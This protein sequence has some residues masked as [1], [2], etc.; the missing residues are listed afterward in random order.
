MSGLYVLLLAALWLGLGW[1]LLRLWRRLHKEK[2]GTPARA[3]AAVLLLVVWVGVPWYYTVGRKV[4][5]DA[6]VRELCAKDGGIKV[7]EAVKLP[8]EK[9]D[10]WGMVKPYDPTQGENALG[11]EYFFGRDTHYFRRGNPEIW[12]T[13]IQIV[14]RVDNKMLGEATRYSRRGGDLPGPW[15]ES[16]FAC[17][18]EAGQEALIQSIFKSTNEGGRQ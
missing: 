13:H 11:S 5:L 3:G 10:K 15:H 8:P 6:Q 12:R 17:P 14:R 4:L 2:I 9:F 18:V 16:S 1:L 7:Y